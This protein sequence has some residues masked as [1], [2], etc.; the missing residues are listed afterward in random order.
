[1][2]LTF[3]SMEMNRYGERFSLA[4]LD[5]ACQATNKFTHKSESFVLKALFGK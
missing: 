5:Q 3:Q 4:A 2:S 1:M